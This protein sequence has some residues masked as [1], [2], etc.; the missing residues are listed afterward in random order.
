M[1]KL[2]LDYFISI[3][4]AGCSLRPC[5]RTPHDYT[6]HPNSFFFFGETELQMRDQN[7]RRVGQRQAR[8]GGMLSKGTWDQCVQTT[9]SRI[10]LL[11]ILRFDSRL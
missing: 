4:D 3:A 11:W 9:A 2:S 8:A 1:I 7:D 5:T 6:T 10:G